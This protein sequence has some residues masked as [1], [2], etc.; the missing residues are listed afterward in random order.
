MRTPAPFDRR[1]SDRRAG[2]DR[3]ASFAADWNTPPREEQRASFGVDRRVASRD[4]RRPDGLEER[5]AGGPQDR[6]AG[7]AEE[8]RAGGEERRAGGEERRGGV[9]DQWKA[10]QPNAWRVAGFEMQIA[11]EAQQRRAAASMHLAVLSGLA[12]GV[13]G[14]VISLFT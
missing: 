9:A 10:A 12:F 7:G 4:A 13:V 5:R 11:Q 2:V 1:A 3:R 8:R 6:R 14:S